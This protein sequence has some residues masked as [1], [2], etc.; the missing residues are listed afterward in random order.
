M[1][2]LAEMMDKHAAEPAADQRADSDWQKGKSHVCTLLPRRREARNIF[3]V[4]WRLR[5]LAKRNRKQRE[6]CH[7]NRRMN[8]QN[9]P[10]EPRDQRPH[11]DRAECGNTLG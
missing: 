2:D 11:S 1:S 8:D 4:A 5:D 9:D 3:V 10:R 6:D 7:R